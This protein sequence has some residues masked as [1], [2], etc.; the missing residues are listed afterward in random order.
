MVSLH[1]MISG[2]LL[3][4]VPRWRQIDRLHELIKATVLFKKSHKNSSI[5]P[6][7]IESWLSFLVV[8]INT[9]ACGKETKRGRGDTFGV[10]L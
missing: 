2:K 5:V 1:C 10:E 8:T 7:T 9:A 4:Y 6:D 3:L